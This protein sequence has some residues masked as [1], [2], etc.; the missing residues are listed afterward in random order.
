MGPVDFLPNW[1]SQT[2]FW[3]YYNQ[4]LITGLIALFVGLSTILYLKNQQDDE[5]KRKLR[6]LRAGLPIALSNI[7]RYAADSLNVLQNFLTADGKLLGSEEYDLDAEEEVLKNLPALPSYPSE[8]FKALQS[9]IEHAELEDAQKL[10]EIIAYGQIH[11]ARFR[12][13]TGRLIDGTD[14]ARI[15][16]TPNLLGAIRDSL[17]MYLHVDRAFN[18]GRESSHKIEELPNAEEAADK[19]MFMQIDHESA[20]QFVL[21]HWPP[22]FPSASLKKNR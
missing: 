15:V 20:R 17:G 10:H 5:R 3:I 21:K 9:A 16:T 13:I 19:L 8:A 14:P 1:L 18:Y 22:N 6:S 4:T 11:E 7:S 2:L 12:S